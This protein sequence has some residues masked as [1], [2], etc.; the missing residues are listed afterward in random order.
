MTMRS[1][2]DGYSLLEVL[3]V[4]AIL[5]AL[6][7]AS[8]GVLT[9]SAPVR[10]ARGEVLQ[11]VAEAR[12]DVIMRGRSG[13]VAVAGGDLTFGPKRIALASQ[14]G[15]TSRLLIYPDGTFAGNR[16][17]FSRAVGTSVDGVFR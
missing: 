11:F 1:L 17:E 15:L 16:A 9:P 2:D 6:T 14:A 13:V 8:V 10:D 5:A 4:L 3:V 7:A 12:I